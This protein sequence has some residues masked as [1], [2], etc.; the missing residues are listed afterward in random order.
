MVAVSEEMDRLFTRRPA[1]SS[2]PLAP[3]HVQVH[4]T[5]DAN[6]SSSSLGSSKSIPDT[7]EHSEDS[8]ELRTHVPTS[9]SPAESPSCSASSLTLIQPVPDSD[10]AEQASTS[11]VTVDKNDNPWP[12][13]K[14]YFSFLGVKSN[15][16]NAEY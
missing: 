12:Y 15:G 6:I 5:T 14:S 2:T 8:E 3:V 10:S 13:L 11:S 7:D 1:A 9:M 16:K 4:D